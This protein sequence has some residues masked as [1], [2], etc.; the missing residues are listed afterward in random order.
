MIK[1]IFNPGSY[2]NN[3]H[4]VLLLL[5]VVVGAFMLTHGSGKF[6]TLFGEE[7]IR[8]ADPI[9]IGE[10]ASLVLAVFAEVLCSILL[11]FGIAT[12]LATIPLIITMLVAVLIVHANDGFDHKE[13]PLFYLV[14]YLCLTI[15]GAG[16]ISMDHWIYQKINRI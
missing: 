5:R 16:K 13:L 3:I 4:L 7:P 2:P 10:P 11:I 14:V 15:T 8:F 12:R 1:T 6:S 9:G